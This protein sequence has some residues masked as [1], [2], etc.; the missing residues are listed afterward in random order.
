[1]TK[2]S[3]YSHL[4]QNDQEQVSLLLAEVDTVLASETP[5]S[6]EKLIA[7]ASPRLG[8]ALLSQVLPSFIKAHRTRHGVTPTLHELRLAHPD[9]AEELSQSYP[10]IPASEQLPIE[11]RGYRILSVIGEGGQSVVLRAQDDVHSA[12]AIKVSTSVDHNPLILRERKLLGECEHPGIIQVISSGSHEGRAYFVMPHLRG[13][14]LVDRYSVR[15]PTASEVVQVMVAVCSAL[16]HL[17]SRGIVHRDIK[18]ANIWLDE[19]GEVKLIDLG[20]AVQRTSWSQPLP[21]IAEFNGTPAFM[22]PEQ[23]SSDGSKDSE[24]SDVFSAGATLY[25]M[26]TGAAPFA[27]A[28]TAKSIALAANGDYD[29][30]LLHSSQGYPHALKQACLKAMES[31]P[32]SRFSSA[33]DFSGKLEAIR[34][35]KLRFRLSKPVKVFA[36]I[37]VLLLCFASVAAVLPGGNDKIVAD[38]LPEPSQAS[39]EPEKTEHESASEKEYPPSN[40]DQ[41]TAKKIEPPSSPISEPKL[42]AK[43]PLEDP[44]K[45]LQQAKQLFARLGPEDKLATFHLSEF[46]LTGASK[47]AA[48]LTHVHFVG[49]YARTNPSSGLKKLPNARFGELK[50]SELP[51]SSHSFMKHSNEIVVDFRKR[52]SS[53][54][55]TLPPVWERVFFKF[56]LRDGSFTPLYIAKSSEYFCGGA[57]VPVATVPASAPFETYMYI[58]HKQSRIPQ[59]SILPFLDKS[60]KMTE[61]VLRECQQT[62]L[63]LMST[64][65]ADA[66][67]VEH[68]TDRSFTQPA[69]VAVPGTIYARY[70][71]DKGEMMGYSTYHFT[72]AYIKEMAD[73][74]F[75]HVAKAGSST[76]KEQPIVSDPS[77]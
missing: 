15:K 18:P 63:M 55:I 77:G 1:M 52:P 33:A 37:V 66:A 30:D 25:W 3:P 50:E 57:L 23:A 13:A 45:Q 71:N 7:D 67:K 48:Q 62:R 10:W 40:E 44:I 11:I 41:V 39:P 17:H 12:V 43:P 36:L 59:L 75:G 74:A 68:F 76:E 42:Q 61:S 64:L 14:T 53:L 22:S 21:A 9:L 28:D 51:K 16:T 4:N 54:V 24:L 47:I 2:V 8:V 58:A 31:D 35:G 5:G 38:N 56:R 46:K 73:H 65:P 34:T 32:A 72:E 69:H 6:L 19:S 26:L 27:S 60:K 20:M 70:M 29:K 49:E